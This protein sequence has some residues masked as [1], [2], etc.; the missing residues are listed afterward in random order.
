MLEQVVLKGFSILGGT[1]NSTG[2]RP[3]QPVISSPAL[4]RGLDQIPEVPSKLNHLVI[5]R[6]NDAVK[7]E[8]GD[9]SLPFSTSSRHIRSLCYTSGI[10][11]PR[12]GLVQFRSRGRWDGKENGCQQVLHFH[13]QALKW[14]S[15]HACVCL[16]ARTKTGLIS[17]CN[18]GCTNPCV[19]HTL[20]SWK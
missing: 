20:C 3:E 1:P 5:L 13:L 17:F 14:S 12:E 7:D 10:F 15:F 19:F 6:N 11:S 8:P 9:H 2:H 18:S 4:S 16:G